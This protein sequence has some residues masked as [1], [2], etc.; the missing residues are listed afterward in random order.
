MAVSIVKLG[1][2]QFSVTF[3]MLKGNEKKIKRI[4]K[5]ILFELED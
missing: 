2:S 5:E 4:V 3:A 1:V